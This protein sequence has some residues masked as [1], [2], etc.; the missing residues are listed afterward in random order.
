[1]P[2]VLRI[3][4]RFNLGG[5]T[6]N[7]AYLTRYLPE[8]YNTVLA[9][10]P[11][12]ASEGSSL[13][14]TEKLGIK[15][16]IIPEL[17]RE[18]R[19]GSD[20]KAYRILKQLIRETRP[21]IVHTHASKAGAIGRLAAIHAGV[22]VIVHTFHGHVFHSYF[23]T[24]KTAFYK[25]IERY[26]AKRSHAIVAISPLQKK[27]LTETYRICSKEQTHVIPLGFDL[28]RFS[29]NTVSKRAAFRERFKVNDGE[30]AIGIIGR[31]APV[32]NHHLFIDAVAYVNRCS[33]KKIRA[34]IIGDGELK[35]ELCRYMT[36]RELAFSESDDPPAL[37]RFTGWQTEVD[38]V[39]AGLDM[40]CLS[41]KNEGTPV[42]LIEAQ[43]AGK[44]ILTTNVGGVTDIIEPGCGTITPPDDLEAYQTALL[45][46]VENIE[47]FSAAVSAAVKTIQ[48]KFS[49]Q[50]LIKDMD[51]L[52]QHLLKK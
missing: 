23:G 10:G 17:Q 49:Y 35:N 42:S 27:E 14:I 12:E 3:I 22:P 38:A 36:E 33:S 24:L 15:P 48:E 26:L 21:D 46:I 7:V 6:Y 29:E 31:L 40:V 30:I 51:N 47:T 39:L 5:P 19:F 44:Y 16:I 20:I 18:I 4:N 45:H 25:V 13:H 50:R 28:A 11:E 1:M 52:Y 9:G 34:F 41:S 43:A 8:A 37:F 32:K 2:R